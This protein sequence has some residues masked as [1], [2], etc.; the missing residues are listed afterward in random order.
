MNKAAR[1]MMFSARGRQDGHE[2]YGD[3][4]GTISGG[5]GR[6]DYYRNGAT[7]DDWDGDR[8]ED[9]GRRYDRRDRDDYRDHGRERTHRRDYGGYD[10][11]DGMRDSRGSH[12]GYGDDGD[13]WGGWGGED[14]REHERKKRRHAEEMTREDA[15]KWVKKMRTDSDKLLSPIAYD[16]A[17]RI[18][19]SY[20]M[21]D[22]KKM[23]EFY[24]A[25]NMVKSDYQSVAK[26]YGM[27]TIEFYA[28]M[29]KAF[30]CDKDAVEDKLSIYKECIVKDD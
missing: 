21:T 5:Y 2:R 17:Q 7:R 22:P 27:D 12:G 28:D 8:R 14:R 26:K 3:R 24:A 30:L 18:A 19:P 29:A 23:V 11:D 10:R 20:G 16:D 6:M 13:T 1:M 25:M 15:E 9:Y 4:Y